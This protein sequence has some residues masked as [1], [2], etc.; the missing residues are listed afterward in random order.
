MPESYPWESGTSR[1]NKL[2]VL[3]LTSPQLEDLIQ[4]WGYR[5]S[6]SRK[7][8]GFIHRYGMNLPLAFKA[9]Q[10]PKGLWHRLF[11]DDQIAMDPVSAWTAE[12]SC[13]SSTKYAFELKSGGT[14]EG[15]FMP[16]EHRNTLCISSQVGCAMGC[17]FCA[18]GSMGFHRHLSAGEMVSQVVRMRA[19]HPDPK[20]WPR[21]FNVV[22]M[23]MGEPLHNIE[24]VMKAV[25]VLTDDAGLNLTARDIAVSTSGLVPRIQQLAEYP[26]RPQLMVSIA[27]TTDKARSQ[28]MPVN[29]AYPLAELRQCL[30]NYPLRKREKIMLSYVLISDVNDKLADADRLAELASEFPSVVNLIPMNEHEASPGMLEPHGD[31]VQLFYDRLIQKGAFATIRRSRGRDVAGACGQLVQ[32]LSKGNRIARTHI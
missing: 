26:N 6:H 17:T 18:T 24:Q 13:D 22:F 9:S 27:A 20:G 16:F 30:G 10:L 21:R 23:G 31:R 32:T 14:V 28:I 29:R 25:D 3:D 11:H 4:S 7:L 15:V 5:K 2:H 19:Q 12:E 1:R 8:F